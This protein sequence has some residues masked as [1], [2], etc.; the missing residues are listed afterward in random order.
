MVVL[1][2]HSNDFSVDEGSDPVDLAEI[3]AMEFNWRCRRESK[4]HLLIE[5]EG[6]WRIYR[7]S[8]SLPEDSDI[9]SVQA[10]FEMKLERCV[11][12]ELLRTVNFANQVCPIGSFTVHWNESAFIFGC[13]H[14]LVGGASLSLEQVHM[15][16]E[17]S[18]F[19]CERFY[20]AF[21]MVAYGAEDSETA[22][23]CALLEP[24]GTC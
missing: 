24:R 18:I 4:N 11:R 13:G 3:V 14:T 16:L 20:P 7:I 22:I 1:M 23:K 21:Q 17:T 9:L 2:N 8:V 10:G 5:Y 12:G 19:L 15:L 6:M